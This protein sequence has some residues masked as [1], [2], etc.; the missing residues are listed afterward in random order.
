MS[1]MLLDCPRGG[2]IKKQ[3]KKQELLEPEDE[4]ADLGIAEESRIPFRAEV[5]MG[6]LVKVTKKFLEIE[7]EGEVHAFQHRLKYRELLE[8][9]DRYGGKIIVLHV[10]NYQVNRLRRAENPQPPR[11][12]SL[13]RSMV[14]A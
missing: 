14:I 13:N 8:L 12:P 9:V 7:S 3:M 5:I 1:K 2:S 6:R 4:I 10:V 11:R